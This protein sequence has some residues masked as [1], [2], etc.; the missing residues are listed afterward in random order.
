[1]SEEYKLNTSTQRAVNKAYLSA[2]INEPA[3]PKMALLAHGTLPIV[4]E[5]TANEQQG[6]KLNEL[7]VPKGFRVVFFYRPD[8]NTTSIVTCPRDIPNACKVAGDMERWQFPPGTYILRHPLMTFEVNGEDGFYAC[9]DEEGEKRLEK[10]QDQLAAAKKE[11]KKRFTRARAEAVNAAGKNLTR[12]ITSVTPHALSLN[13]QEHISLSALLG[14]VANTPGMKEAV[15]ELSK[16][17]EVITIYILACGTNTRTRELRKKT[18]EFF[19]TYDVVFDEPID[20]PDEGGRRVRR[21][22]RRA[23]GRRAR[24]RRART[25]RSR[26]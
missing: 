8:D 17:N 5:I 24:G 13:L 3:G 2:A 16:T 4:R 23:R 12:G 1:M 25:R 6:I 15:E 19:N 14:I 26:S 22:R 11:V 20:D 10:L 9:P 7:I 21:S 18:L